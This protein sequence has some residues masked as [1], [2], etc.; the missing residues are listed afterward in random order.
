LLPRKPI[1]FIDVSIDFS[2]I[3]SLFFKIQ[4]MSFLCALAP[5]VSRKCGI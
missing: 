2:N 1:D 4:K 3:V 5:C